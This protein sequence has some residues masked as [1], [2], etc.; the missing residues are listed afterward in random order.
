MFACIGYVIMVTSLHASLWRDDA[1]R[2]VSWEHMMFVM[3]DITKVS[4]VRF[5]ILPLEYVSYDVLYAQYSFLTQWW[6]CTTFYLTLRIQS[7]Q[8]VKSS[9]PLLIGFPAGNFREIIQSSVP[10]PVCQWQP[11]MSHQG[12]LITSDIP[13]LSVIHLSD[14]VGLLHLTL[15][16]EGDSLR[17]ARLITPALSYD[18]RAADIHVNSRDQAACEARKE[19]G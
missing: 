3:H 6:F 4:H 10:E 19:I 7:A 11:S 14:T 9:L 18:I 1:W 16:R 2:D 8:G 17:I 12:D 5:P 15:I 13:A